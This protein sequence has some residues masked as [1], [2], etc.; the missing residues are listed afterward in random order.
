MIRICFGKQLAQ[1]AIKCGGF[2]VEPRLAIEV[3][4]QC[5]C[6]VGILQ[7]TNN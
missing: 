2:L 5:S 1:L 4:Q 3:R 7:R 6:L